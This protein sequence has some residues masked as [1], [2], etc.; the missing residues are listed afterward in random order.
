MAI[1]SHGSP[2]PAG[3]N[4]LL[5]RPFRTI[6]PSTQ[7]RTEQ[8]ESTSLGQRLIKLP[9]LESVPVQHVILIMT[10]VA[11]TQAQLDSEVF[12]TAEDLNSGL[13]TRCVQIWSDL[14]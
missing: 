12:K 5:N 9:D 7:N 14:N 1:E 2:Q 3:L 13:V 10:A 11:V 8:R 6:R 4:A